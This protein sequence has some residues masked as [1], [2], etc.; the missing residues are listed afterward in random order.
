MEID[1]DSRTS[2]DFDAAV[3]FD[4]TTPTNEEQEIV[5]GGK[6]SVQ[7]SIS[8]QELVREKWTGL[9]N[10]DVEVVVS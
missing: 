2:V 10:G 3:L 6:K 7:F 5:I 1:G 8:S 9:L 4:G